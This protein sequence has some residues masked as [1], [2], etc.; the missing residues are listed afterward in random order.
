MNTECGS[1]GHCSCSEG[2]STVIGNMP[3]IDL[4]HFSLPDAGPKVAQVN[5]FALQASGED[6]NTQDLRQ[7]ACGELLRQEAQRCGLLDATDSDSRDGALSEAASN[8]IEALLDQMLHLPEP[9]EE[10]CRRHHAAHLA[11]YSLGERVLARHILFAVVA[12]VDVVAL[13][14]RAEAVLLD[15]RCHDGDLAHS[16]TAF[17]AAAG[18]WS[19]CPS[20]VSGGMLG[21]LTTTDCAQEFARPLFGS[22]EIGVMPQLVHSRFGLHVVEVLAREAG[23]PQAFEAVR[24][25]VLL[26]LQ[27]QSY[28]T[29]LRQYLSVLAGQAELIGVAIGPVET[30]VVQ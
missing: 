29:A 8:A 1:G 5:G 22:A 13:R 6:I 12:G 30:P 7:R 17:K 11:R 23:L 3:P 10:A 4:A 19:N 18:Q 25:A 9:S 21:W 14:Q 20:G 24:G 27:Q 16:D 28:I 15:V 26:A 2:G